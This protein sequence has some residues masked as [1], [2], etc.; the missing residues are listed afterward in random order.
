MKEILRS[1]SRDILKLD[2]VIIVYAAMP[3]DAFQNMLLHDTISRG[4]FIIFTFQ[5]TS[6]FKEIDQLDNSQFTD[7]PPASPGQ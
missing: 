4:D 7:L 3:L 2:L 6:L 5:R 1:H